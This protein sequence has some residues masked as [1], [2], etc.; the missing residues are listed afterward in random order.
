MGVLDADGFLTITD[1]HQRRDHPRRREHLRGRGRAGDR[2]DG[3]ASPRSRSS[4]CPTRGSVS[5]PA[6]WCGSHPGVPTLQLD[7]VTTAVGQAGL[8]RQKWPEEL[9][10]VDDFP[11]T[12][13]GKIRKVDLRAQLRPGAER[14]VRTD[15]RVAHAGEDRHAGGA[16]RAV[17]LRVADLRVRRA[18]G[19]RRP[20]RGAGARP[21]GPG[22]GPTRRS[23]R[24]WRCSPP[25]VFTGQPAVD[26]QRAVGDE[27]LLLAV[28][29]EAV[30]GE[31]D[32]LGAGVGVLQLDHV[33]VLGADARRSRT[34]RATRRP[35]GPTVSSIGSHGLC[36]SNAPSRRV[37]TVDAAR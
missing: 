3:G 19:G 14:T 18:P 24:R 20:G 9:L 26:L 5:T 1:R 35:S 28:G 36:T 7:D 25:S 32:H 33:D 8:A 22:A 27:R 34:R 29:A 12:A 6:R 15:G 23:A 17:E 13:T 4:R 11:R 16:G 2:G 30:L 21:R 10:V 31:V 37:R